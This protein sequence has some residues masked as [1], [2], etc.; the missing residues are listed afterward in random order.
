MKRKPKPLARAKCGQ[1][2]KIADLEL[3]KRLMRIR[4]SLATTCAIM[5]CGERT[6]QETIKREFGL[7]FEEFRDLHM[8]E[9]KR[10]LIEKA[11]DKALIG[12]GDNTMLTLCLRNLA[13]WNADRANGPVVQLKNSVEVNTKP[14]PQLVQEF[15]DVIVSYRNERKEPA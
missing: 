4:P 3:L 15:K 2:P 1:K 10:Q 13:D 5:G 9:I 8:A 11:L 14:D 12:E 6:V 7:T